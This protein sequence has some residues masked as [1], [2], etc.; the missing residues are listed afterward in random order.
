MQRVA[1][2]AL[3][4]QFAIVEQWDN[5]HRARVR[6]VLAY[7]HFAIGEACMVL[8]DMQQVAIKNLLAADSG[9][10]K[11]GMFRPGSGHRNGTS[12]QAMDSDIFPQWICLFRCSL[13]P[14]S[15]S[16][17]IMVC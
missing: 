12:L 17:E 16:W 8:V 11:V 13:R 10:G 15:L 3:Q 14:I 2:L 5:D 7:F 1:E 9:F 4:Y 6:D